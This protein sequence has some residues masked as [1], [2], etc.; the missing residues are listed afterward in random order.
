MPDNKKASI[1]DI[2]DAAN[3]SIAKVSRVLNK[4]DDVRAKT[5][6]KV[7][8]SAKKLNYRPDKVARRMRVQS[9]D[10]LVLGLIITDV[11]NPFFQSCPVV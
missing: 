9:S 6:N 11:G 2:A 10:S 5:A 8:E 7:L 4:S 1:K 3:V